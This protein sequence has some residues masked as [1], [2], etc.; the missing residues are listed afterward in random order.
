VTRSKQAGGAAIEDPRDLILR[1]PM[2]LAQKLGV[3]SLLLITAVDGYDILAASLASPSLIA[4]WKITHAQ[5][6]IILAM[7][8]VGMGFGAFF[9]SPMADRFGRRK[10][11]LPFLVA[12]AASMLLGATATG[13]VML[14]ATRLVTGLG[15]GAMVGGSLSLAAEY[16]NAR[17]RPFTIAVMSVGLPL[18]GFAGGAAAAVLLLDYGWRS[19]FLFGG[20]ATLVVALVALVA[21]PESI[22]F[23]I[24][25]GAPDALVAVNRILRRYGH[26]PLSSIPAP[27]QGTRGARTPLLSGPLRATTIAMALINFFQMM[28]IYY[29]ISWLPQMI[30]DRGFSNATAASVTSF[31]NFSGIVGALL[32]GWA[33]RKGGVVRTASIAMGAT[34]LSIIVFALLP[35]SLPLL[36]AGAAVEGFMALGCSAGLFGVLALAFPASARAGGSGLSFGFGRTGSIVATVIPGFLYTAGVNGVAVAGLMAFGSVAAIS[37][38]LFWSRRIAPPRTLSASESI[39]LP[40]AVEA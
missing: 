5:M 1:A 33:A 23:I 2:S 25:R 7:N 22:D 21:I 31:Q 18:G 32:V 36:K 6:G 11:I 35:P 8:L 4:E 34:G 28:T 27:Q 24:N 19:I 38:L 12:I 26:A 39:A 20:C 14:G 3:G 9:L 30:A 37:V 15:I 40:G 16:A 17:N 29:F 10:T 13:P